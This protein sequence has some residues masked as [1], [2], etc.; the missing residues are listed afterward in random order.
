MNSF[1]LQIN[2]FGINENLFY[3]A[4]IKNE[5]PDVLALLD[6]FLTAM[7]LI[8]PIIVLLSVIVFIWGLI[9]NMN[10]KDAESKKQAQ[11]II[12][13]GIIILFVM[14]SVWALVNIIKDA[15]FDDGIKNTLD[16]PSGRTQE[17]ISDL[18]N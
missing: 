10:V 9:M 5:V 8:V 17:K 13:Y 18:K 4:N 6:L 11:N 3:L 15:V 7:N 2:N 14:V 1:L 16:S 12:L